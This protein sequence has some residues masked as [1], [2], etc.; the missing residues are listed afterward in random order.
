MTPRAIASERFDTGLNVGQSPDNRTTADE[1]V[2]AKWS[3]Y[4]EF[5]A[6]VG[7]AAGGALLA[8]ALALAGVS[9][10]VTLFGWLLGG[11]SLT[12]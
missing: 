11:L 4:V 12:N 9:L 6:I 3:E 1:L 7:A 8:P 5:L 2:Q 10:V